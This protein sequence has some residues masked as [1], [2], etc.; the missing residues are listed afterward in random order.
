LDGLVEITGLS[1]PNWR[2]ERAGEFE[3]GF[4]FGSMLVVV[5]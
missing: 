4:G 2:A 3:L 5:L 1:G